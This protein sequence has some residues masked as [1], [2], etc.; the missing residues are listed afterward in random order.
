MGFKRA[1][2]VDDS[3]SARIAL[4]RLLEDQDLEVSLA[5]SG[6]EAINMLRHE[7]V[8]VIFMD[9]TM[10]GMDGLE[11]LSAIKGNPLTATIPVMMYTTKEGEVY[12]SQARALGAIGVL[13][14]QFQ[15]HVLFDMLLDLGL[16]ND[17]RAPAGEAPAPPA[18]ALIGAGERA[19][20]ADYDNQALGM[21][22]QAL[23]TRVLEDQHQSLQADILQS[24]R[25]FARQVAAEIHQQQQASAQ[26]EMPATSTPVADQKPASQTLVSL[27]MVGLTAVSIVLAGL[28]W[29]LLTERDVLRDRLTAATAALE[30][31]QEATALAI[32]SAARA[33]AQRPAADLL[34][35]LTWAINQQGQVPF[36]QPAFNA[37]RAS[38]LRALLSRLAAAGFRGVVQLASHLGSF[39]LITDDAGAY[40]LAPDE[41]PLVDCAFIGHPLGESSTVSERSSEDFLS[42]LQGDRLDSPP[43]I[44]L[45]FI[46]HDSI[47]SVPKVA[48]PMDAEVAGSWNAVAQRNNRVELTLLAEE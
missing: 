37:D 2:V 19:S 15:P 32:D 35:T 28:Y 40:Q 25:D 5:E 11:A 14:K 9:H 43:G 36:A 27:L 48:Y 45:E 29:Q 26:P 6:E 8:D 7:S 33:G 21:S 41:L 38:A 31:A 17:R 30:S 24:H 20:D 12:V 47:S 13:P 16:V 34:Q 10:P 39:C 23:V 22:V 42:D 3:K 4:K 46:A 1:L 44:R 18:R